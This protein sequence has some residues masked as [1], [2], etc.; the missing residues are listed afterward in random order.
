MTVRQSLQLALQRHQANRL[1]E[2]ELLYRQVVKRDP[3]NADACHLLGVMYSE[4]FEL[5]QDYSAAS[6]LFKK[7]C[8]AGYKKAC[9]ELEALSDWGER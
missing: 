5:P 7:A 6:K 2:A 9:E 1:T 4:G 3:R 8:A